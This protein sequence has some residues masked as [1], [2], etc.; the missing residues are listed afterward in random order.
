VTDRLLAVHTRRHGRALEKRAWLRADVNSLQEALPWRTFRW[1]HGQKHFP[2]RY[3]CAI[4]HDH[5]IYESRLELSRLMLADFDTAVRRIAAQP[6][7]L[8][9][10][11]GDGTRK[12][13]PDYLLITDSGPVVVDVKPRGTE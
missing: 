12:H 6:F 13:T 4:E 11:E 3:W 10:V 9:K 7:L 1:H 2:G 8:T 5:V